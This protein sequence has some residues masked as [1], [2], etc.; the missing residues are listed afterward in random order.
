[1]TDL[2]PGLIDLVVAQQGAEPHRTQLRPHLVPIQ[3]TGQ[4]HRR[5]Q[6]LPG[7]IAERGVITRVR[8]I[9]LSIAMRKIE[10]ERSAITAYPG[11]RACHPF[12]PGTQGIADIT[13]TIRPGERVRLVGRSGV[14]KST[15]AMR[16]AAGTE[17]AGLSEDYDRYYPWATSEYIANGLADSPGAWGAAA[18]PCG[19]WA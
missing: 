15:V 14:G 7:G 13:L 10:T 3:R 16:F 17:P 8:S 1:M 2:F 9:A 11:Y 19:C 18:A 5:L 12:H 4:P 6:H